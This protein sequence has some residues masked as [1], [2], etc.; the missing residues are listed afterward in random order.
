MRGHTCIE[1]GQI[2]TLGISLCCSR[3][4]CFETG[5]LTEPELEGS[6]PVDDQEVL[7]VSLFSQ[8]CGDRLTLLHGCPE[9]Q[10]RSTCFHSRP[11]YPLSH[12]WAPRYV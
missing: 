3:S 6:D 8:H 11:P 4:V 5:S 12:L 7:R 10:L 1:G 2:G 9:S